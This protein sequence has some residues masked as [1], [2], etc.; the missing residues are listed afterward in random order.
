MININESLLQTFEENLNPRN[1]EKSPVKA[2][3]LGYGE[4]SSIFSLDEQPGIAFKRMPLFRTTKDAR[5]YARNYKTYCEHLGKAGLNI[6]EDK[7]VIIQLPGRPVVLYIAQEQLPAKGF[8]HNQ[9]HAVPRENSLELIGRIAMQ[10]VSVWKYNEKMKPGLELSLDGQLSN[11]VEENGQLYFVDTSTPLFRLDGKEQLDPELLLQSAPGF[12]RWI[13]RAFFLDDVMNRYYD[14]RQVYMDLAAN[15]YKE[16]KP[17]LIPG[18]LEIVNNNLSDD[19]ATITE[20]EVEKYY[21]ED[22]LIWSLFLAFRRFDR[23]MK[24]KILHK[25]YEF[26]LPGKIKR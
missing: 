4:I 16:Q 1:M 3:V 26:I 9:I 24:T 15:L 5:G 2:E 6:P 7:T 14:L 22:K 19:A 23:W 18:V 25:R 21:R 8:G 11:W 20:K 12:L 10:I 13:L 17:E